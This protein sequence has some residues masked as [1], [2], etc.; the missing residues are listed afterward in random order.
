VTKSHKNKP[1]II[2]LDRAFWLVWLLFPSLLWLTYRSVADASLIP[3][4]YPGIDPTCL[5][6]LPQVPNFTQGGKIATY[7]LVTAQLSMYALMLAFAHLTIHRFAKGRIFVQDTLKTLS[8]IAWAVIIWPIFDLIASNIW[9]YVIYR[10]GDM[11]SYVPY[12]ALDVAPIGVGLLLLTMR[13]AI[14][15]AIVMK[16]DQDL[17]I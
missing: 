13:V 15:H 9:Q 4:L 17:T 8:L 1:L 16:Q 10:T 6:K 3:E 12:S 11:P 7:I 5:E 14:G 2:W